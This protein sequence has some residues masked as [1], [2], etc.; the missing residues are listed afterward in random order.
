MDISL[1]HLLRSLCARKVGLSGWS[2]GPRFSLAFLDHPNGNE[3]QLHF[4]E[5]PKIITRVKCKLYL[6]IT[7]A[8]TLVS[9]CCYNIFKVPDD[10]TVYCLGLSFFWHQKLSLIKN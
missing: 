10:K 6:Y 7:F 2:G 3:G 4:I 9:R 8:V 5:L 1:S